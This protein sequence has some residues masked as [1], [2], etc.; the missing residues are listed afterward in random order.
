M[1]CFTGDSVESSDWLLLAF[2]PKIL[3]GGMDLKWY[4][5]AIWMQFEWW[6]YD[7]VV[8]T[9]CN[10]ICL[11]VLHSQA[12]GTQT[13]W[14]RA[15][16]PSLARANWW[17]FHH[18]IYTYEILCLVTCYTCCTYQTVKFGIFTEEGLPVLFLVVH[19]RLDVHV[20]AIGRRTV[21][22]LWRLLT[23]LKQ[24]S[25]QRKQRMSIKQRLHFFTR[26]D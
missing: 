20:K 24:Q 7:V 9:L 13:I 18:L 2:C 25:H 14:V 11:N 21:R 12:V 1:V 4:F 23:L 10:T 19:E 6:G 8:G 26:Q 15:L 3:G 22:G 16:T 5:A 17:N